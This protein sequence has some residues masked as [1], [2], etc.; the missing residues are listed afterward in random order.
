MA[1]P[2]FPGQVTS[3][4][5]A[6]PDVS[7]IDTPALGHMLSSELVRQLSKRGVAVSTVGAAQAR[8]SCTVV[9]LGSGQVPLV[10]PSTLSL[11]GQELVLRLDLRLT[12]ANGD[13]LWRSGLLE[14]RRLRARV[15]A[16][17]VSDQAA[18]QQA[19]RALASA[20]AQ[21]AVEALASGL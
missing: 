17:S 13:T 21:E 5:V 16:S 2:T 11:A 6:P 15:A 7:Q 9:S 12:S 10:K 18:R 14:V 3:V 19:V 8:L 20:A 1:S 4:L